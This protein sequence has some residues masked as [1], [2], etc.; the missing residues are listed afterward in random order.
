MAYKGQSSFGKP[1][2]QNPQM[3]YEYLTIPRQNSCTHEHDEGTVFGDVNILFS[4]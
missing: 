3:D 4:Y 2:I 1:V